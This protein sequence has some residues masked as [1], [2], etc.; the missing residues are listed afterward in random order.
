M[1][2]EN[3]EHVCPGPDECN[4]T[5]ARIERMVTDSK[6]EAEKWADEIEAIVTPVDESKP[7]HG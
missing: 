6:A 1:T 4:C 3:G 5:L 7:T 2:V